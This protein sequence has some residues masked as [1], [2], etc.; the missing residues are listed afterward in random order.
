MTSPN[1]PILKELLNRF[2][3]FEENFENFKQEMREFRDN[4]LYD[5]YQTS[6]FQE[7][8]DAELFREY[9]TIGYPTL[10][11]ELCPFKIF[12]NTNGKPI[13]DIDGCIT[14]DSFPQTPEK[15]EGFKNNSLQ[16]RNLRNAIFFIESKNLLDKVKLDNKIIQ[17]T[18]I[19]PLIKS[20]KNIKSN[21]TNNLA[22]ASEN[23]R[24]M[25]Q[26]YPLNKHPTE[27]YLILSAND[28]SLRIR[29]F[30]KHIN[31][32]TLTEEIYKNSI[33]EMFL[34]HSVYKKIGQTIA[35]DQA[36]HNSYKSARTY[37]AFTELFEH[38]KFNK[39]IVFLNSFFVN[40]N[41]VKQA[42][43]KVKG[44]I[45][46]IYYGKVTMPINF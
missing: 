25:I 31:S 27:I 33:C 45:G 23:F 17:L 10:N 3:K 26:S 46:Y 24:E 29:D 44:L 21:K 11:V 39:H 13:T 36:L 1:T 6:I 37:D 34:E 35:N 28:M 9:M 7:K 16:T 4:V 2:T 18:K 5:K 8:E 40:Y 20:I 19:L 42:Y 30:I 12:Y 41:K 38:E 14:V 32:D 43:S 22:Y 15:G